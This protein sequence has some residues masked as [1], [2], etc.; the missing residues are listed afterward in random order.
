MQLPGFGVHVSLWLASVGIGCA[1]GSDT[2]RGDTA[3][4]IGEGGDGTSGTTGATTVGVTATT[5]DGECVPGQQIE[6]GCP[7]GALGAQACQP[8]G[9]GYLPC[10]CPGDDAG[11]AVDGSGG[12]SESTSSN[13]RMSSSDGRM[14]SSDGRVSSSDGGTNDCATCGEAALAGE[15]GEALDACLADAACETMAACVQRC[16]LSWPCVQQCSEGGPDR[17]LFTALADCVGT[18]CPSCLEP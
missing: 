17:M 6:C 5:S 14:S 8:D 11:T 2:T 10:G 16:G 4:E 18:A 9:S 12:P 1:G 7:G 15:C 13:G 3:A